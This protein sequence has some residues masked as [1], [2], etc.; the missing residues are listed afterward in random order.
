MHAYPG[1][2]ISV[3]RVKSIVRSSD[4]LDPVVLNRRARR[5]PANIA[6]G[7]YAFPA[8]NK[9]PQTRYVVLWD[10][11]VWPRPATLRSR[12]DL[13]LPP[14]RRTGPRRALGAD[15]RAHANEYGFR[16]H[17][18][19]DRA[20]VADSDAARSVQHDKS[21]VFAFSAHLAGA[22]STIAGRQRP[23]RQV[24]LIPGHSF[25]LSAT[26]LRRK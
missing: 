7:R 19:R 4:V 12:T 16:V 14:L 11:H 3:C 21:V 24:L 8:F 10:L 5:R 26:M 15:S 1:N 25:G 23:N 17:S 9:A 22:T 20:A 6:M 18:A 2:F 13:L